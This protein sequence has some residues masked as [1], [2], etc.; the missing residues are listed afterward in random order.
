MT[1]DSGPQPMRSAPGDGDLATAFT[2]Q[3]IAVPAYDLAALVRLAGDALGAT[4]ARL[5]IPDYASLSLHELGS[6][7]PAATRIPI[8]GTLAGRSYIKDE[9][10]ATATDP[11]TVLVPIGQ[12]SERIGVLEL[13]LGSWAGSMTPAMEGLVR[14]LV[15]VLMSKRR[16]TDVLVRSRRSE[17][18]SVAAEVQWDL[19]PPLSCITDRVSIAGMLEPAYSIGGDSFDYALNPGFAEF[20]IVDAVGHGMPAVLKS[21]IAVQALRNAR[22]EGRSLEE[23]YLT[24]GAIV[25]AEYGDCSFVTGQLGALELGT[26]NLTWLNA[27]HPLPLLVRDGSFAGELQCPP[28]LPM[29]LGGRPRAVATERLQ[30]GD[31]V[32]FYTDGVIET[33]STTGEQFG[34]DRLADYLVRA[35]LDG[36]HPTETV[37]RL[38]ALIVSYN[39]IG[40]SD[41]A[42]LLLLE[43]R[44]DAPPTEA[45]SALGGQATP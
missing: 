10:V 30:T 16:Y 4:S 14:S 37:R 25:E 26:G 31:R 35:T 9:V 19:L 27:G 5:L 2:R 40:L 18:L 39:G 1:N 7:D 45:E 11:A 23:A 28:S 24:T 6:D 38:S 8:E 12:D 44:G 22:R 29:G 3:V 43:Y 21:V 17:P 41:D 34:V 33:R 13:S 42:T 15:L 36:V 20:A 32:L